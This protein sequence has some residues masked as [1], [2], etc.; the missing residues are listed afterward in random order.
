MLFHNSASM[1]TV[2][3]KTIHYNSVHNFAK[4]FYWLT[5]YMTQVTTLKKWQKLP[6][7]PG[8]VMAALCNRGG[9]LYFFPVISIFFYLSF[10][11]S[12]NLSGRRLDVYHT[13]TH[14][15]ALVRILNAGLKC[16]ARGSLQSPQ[17]SPSG[18]HRTTL[19]GYIFATTAHIDNRKNTC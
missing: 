5:V 16:S 19:S 7:D 2:S 8:V 10:F 13:L 3:Q 1:Y 18:H 12:P 14:G 11:S 9:P 17:K 4:C 15:V 6:P